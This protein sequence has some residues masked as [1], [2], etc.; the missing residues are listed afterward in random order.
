MF[1]FCFQAFPSHDVETIH[2]FEMTPMRR[3]KV[4]VQTAGHVSGAAYY[5]QRKDV[6]PDA[7][8]AKQVLI[9]NFVVQSKY[10][11]SPGFIVITCENIYYRLLVCYTSTK[12]WRGYIFIAVCLCVC[13]RVYRYVCLSVCPAVFLWTKF[14]LKGCTDFDMIL[15]KWLLTALAQTLL[16]LHF[17]L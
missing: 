4:L 11:Y 6:Q 12:L 1:S 5:Y 13:V 7:W 16:K 14:Q 15:A 17:N 8:D 3:P 10:A 9:T 2:D